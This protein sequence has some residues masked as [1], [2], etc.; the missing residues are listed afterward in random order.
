MPHHATSVVV[1]RAGAT[2]AEVLASLARALN[3]QQG[4]PVADFTQEVVL[5]DGFGPA[6]LF[7]AWL[8]EVEGQAMGYA[9]VVSHAYETGY[10][11]AGVYVQDLFVSPE[12]RHRGLGRALMAAVAADTR[13]RGLRFL[14]WASRTWNTASHDFY[15]TL[16]TAEE[17]VIAFATF[18]DEFTRLADEG[19]RFVSVHG[20]SDAAREQDEAER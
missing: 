1:R 14:W 4:D 17:P 13:A 8:A 6:P 9:L 10:A 2:D 3:V 18:G 16:A 5:R 19:A 15:R 7:E 11:Q 12:A 20:S